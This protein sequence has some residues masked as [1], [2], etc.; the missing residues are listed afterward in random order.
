LAGLTLGVFYGCQKENTLKDFSNTGL[1]K[2]V[3]DKLLI[4]EAKAYFESKL[5]E[6][7]KQK[8]ANKNKLKVRDNQSTDAT[9]DGLDVIPKWDNSKVIRQNGSSFVET[10]YEFEGGKQFSLSISKNSN[11]APNEKSASRLIV[12]KNSSGVQSANFMAVSADDEYLNGTNTSLKN[13][14]YESVP[15]KF[16]GNEMHFNIDGSFKNGWSFMDGKVSGVIKKK[17]VGSLGT[18]GDCWVEFCQYPN[19][20][21]YHS[22]DQNQGGEFTIHTNRQT[23]DY[24]RR[25]LYCEGWE[26]Q[27][28]SWNNNLGNG[29]VNTYSNDEPVIYVPTEE[30]KW[31][32]KNDTTILFNNP[33]AKYVYNNLTKNAGNFLYRTIEGFF[34]DKPVI[35][36]KW[37]I[38]PITYEDGLG[39]M[40]YIPG[41]FSAK[42]TLNSSFLENADPTMIAAVII[43][44]AMH[45]E[46]ARKIQSIGGVSNLNNINF[47]AL[48]NYYS[49]Y[50]FPDQDHNYLADNYVNK[51]LTALK[52]FDSTAGIAIK[53]DFDYLSMIWGGLKATDAFGKLSP[54]KQQS[55]LTRAGELQYA[56]GCPH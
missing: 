23:C 40:L 18:R 7:R 20:Y 49:N 34:G 41:E 17:A 11:I 42:I 36:L 19:T 29:W 51:F 37:N 45:A 27:D 9:F 48:F 8:E 15:N 24:Q 56:G 30:E 14:T 47:P 44:E 43:H 22:Q 38:S 39:E 13:F 52:D 2:T 3:E 50:T 25:L 16:K 33:C 53:S 10:P 1:S 54:D 28:Q 5:Q 35:H 26:D 4:D 31:L 12:K 6:L 32:D 21:S 55:Y 46:L